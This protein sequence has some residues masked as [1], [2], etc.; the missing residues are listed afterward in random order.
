MSESTKVT[1]EEA[2]SCHL[3]PNPGKLEVVPTTPM[4]TQRDL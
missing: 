4:S 3:E 2:L 1:K